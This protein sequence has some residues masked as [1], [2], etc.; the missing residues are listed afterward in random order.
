MPFQGRQP[1]YMHTG[2]THCS[3]DLKPVLS[4]RQQLKFSYLYGFCLFF[5]LTITARK[6]AIVVELKA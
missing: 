6:E 5:L 4:D 1:A 3:L 2:M